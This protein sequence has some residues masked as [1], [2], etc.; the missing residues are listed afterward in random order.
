M[1][2]KGNLSRSS[3]RTA[4]NDDLEMNPSQH[5]VTQLLVAW[6]NGDKVA[7]VNGASRSPFLLSIEAKSIFT[8][9]ACND[10]VDAS[11]HNEIL[12]LPSGVLI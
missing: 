8:R 11:P 3:Q 1:V 12:Q 10:G 6:S 2:R 5:E 4:R 9:K 7:V